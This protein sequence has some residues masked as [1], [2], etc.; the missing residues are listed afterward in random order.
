[1]FDAAD[2]DI[3]ERL[4]TLSRPV[5]HLAR[6]RPRSP[7]GRSST[8]PHGCRARVLGRRTATDWQIVGS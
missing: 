4:Q 7:L 1:L 5:L 3:Q 6:P 2:L 8:E